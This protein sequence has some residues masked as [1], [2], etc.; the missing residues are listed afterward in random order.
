[1]V[2]TT[3]NRNRSEFLSVKQPRSI[4]PFAVLKRFMRGYDAGDDITNVAMATSRR[5]VI[6]RS[7]LPGVIDEQNTGLSSSGDSISASIVMPTDRISRY[8]LFDQMMR[9]PIISTALNIHVSTAL[10]ID[11][12]SGLC[13]NLAPINPGDKETSER[14][15]ELMNDLGEMINTG[16]PSWAVIMATF[17]T[18]Y[19]RP[20]AQQGKGIQ[21]FECSYYTLPHFISEFYRGGDLAGFTGD[22]LLN[23]QTHQRVLAKPW[24][25]VSLKNPYWIPDVNDRPMVNGTTGYSLLEDPMQRTLAETQNYGTSFL[26]YSYEP[27]I[28]LCDALRSLKAARRNSAIIDRIIAMSTDELDPVNAAAHLRSVSQSLKRSMD[29][30]SARSRNGNTMPTVLN[31]LVP[32]MGQSKG[33]VTFDTQQIP[34]DISGI[35]DVMFHLRQLCASC[36]SDASLM[37]WSDQMS[38]GLG[39]GGWA[40]TAIQ[41]AQRSMWIRNAAQT[42]LYRIIDIHCAYKYGKVYQPGNRPFRVEFNSNNNA[43]QA[44]NDR[45]RE[46]SVNFISAL[47]GIL[48]AMQN[49]VKMAGSPTLMT[50]LLSDQLKMPLDTVNKIYAEFQ[51]QRGEDDSM[52]ES[53]PTNPGIRDLT[54]REMASLLEE[55]L[56]N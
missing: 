2:R 44:E 41:A 13:F 45:E 19:V 46:S 3:A 34:V 22:Y 56:K 30:V 7:V 36:G 8:A 4:N 23:P 16:L 18:S 39:E 12:K 9:S 20:Y 15:K 52:L 21:G 28:N 25:L 5:G 11:K 32:V 51:A 6:A 38:G 26:E 49:N 55:L 35:E 14:C 50:A 47:V 31:H 48:D 40:Q 27:Y 54:K 53:A 37:G 29:E 1:M 17:G 10:S 33:S 24:D 42:A 43:I